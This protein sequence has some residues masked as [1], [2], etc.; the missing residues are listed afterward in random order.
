M[1][2][3]KSDKFFLF[4]CFS[5]CYTELTNLPINK[6]SPQIHSVSNS[7]QLTYLE[8]YEGPQQVSSQ[9]FDSL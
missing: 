3:Q 6:A 8:H 2:E 7:A 5:D 9:Q 1:T 4:V